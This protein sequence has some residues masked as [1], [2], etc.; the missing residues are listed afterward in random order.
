[1]RKG[2]VIPCYNEAKRLQ[3]E[4]FASFL[5]ENENYLICFVNDG[6]KDNTLELLNEFR[7]GKED[8]VLVYDMPQNGGK[9][10]AVRQGTLYLLDQEDVSSVGFLDAD[11]A[12]GFED[13][14]MLTSVLEDEGK[15]FILG[16]RKMIKNDNIQRSFFRDVVS[17]MIGMLI[18]II[19]GLPVK[20]SQCGA[21]V[22]SSSAAKY[23]F[24]TPFRS[25]W[26]FDVEMLIRI[27]KLYGAQV[28]NKIK[29]VAISKWDEVE[30]SHITLKDSL[31][32]PVKLLEIG[33]HYNVA[34]VAYSLITLL[35][36][37]LIQFTIK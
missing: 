9:A 21:K 10:E 29:E 26:L 28:M 32:F 2:I 20:D 14:M 3:F 23:I 19:T 1:M 36:F 4:Q 25:K 13:Y 12:T 31:K 11:L 15:V 16:S 18:R 35:S 37:N 7:K 17:K 30:G 27:K 22:F 6:S 34:P 8:K 33:L 24:S 5:K